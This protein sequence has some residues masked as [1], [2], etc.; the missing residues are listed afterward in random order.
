[1]WYLAQNNGVAVPDAKKKALF[2]QISM[3]FS[4][5]SFEYEPPAPPTPSFFFFFFNRTMAPIRC[6]KNR[7]MQWLKGIHVKRV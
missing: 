5:E 4:S 1:M 6:I 2:I 7:K 3:L